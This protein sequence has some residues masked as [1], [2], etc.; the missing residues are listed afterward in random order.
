MSHPSLKF[1]P[2]FL[3][4]ALLLA[5]LAGCQALEELASKNA[6]SPAPSFSQA[7][8]SSPAAADAPA[9]VQTLPTPTPLATPGLWASPIKATAL[10]NPFGNTYQFYSSYRSGHTGV[11]L[12][13][14][15]GTPV[16]AVA[17]GVVVKT[18]L[19]PNM[20]Y[21]Y[22]IVIAHDQ[23]PYH[24]LY[25]HLSRILVK[26]NTHVKAGEQIGSSGRSGLASY[27]HLHFELL[28]KLPIHDGAWG[29]RYICNRSISWIQMLDK[30]PMGK[31]VGLTWLAANIGFIDVPML[32]IHSYLRM[33]NNQCVEKP[34][35]A[36]TYFNPEPYLPPY[37]HAQMPDLSGN[38]PP[39]N[40][41]HQQTGRSGRPPLSQPPSHTLPSRTP[42]PRTPAGRTTPSARAR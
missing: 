39:R 22:Y 40:A 30:K 2:F 16:Y 36:V 34:I 21:G 18:M 12:A 27:S 13:A 11:D 26:P 25:G 23:K 17:D 19:K 24:T 28:N 41:L 9:P 37:P 6:T 31:V 10:M 8:G 38:S 5:L 14:P 7:P 1:S 35:A 32:A 4:P 33:A 3:L 20:R 42:T 15:V 29:Y